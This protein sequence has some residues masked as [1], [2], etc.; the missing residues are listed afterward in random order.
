MT[1]INMIGQP[2]P[3]PVVEAKKAM[4]Q[5][6]S[7]GVIVLVDNPIA[8]QNLEKMAKGTGCGFSWEQKGEGE[9]AVTILAGEPEGSPAV[10]QM[11][12]AGNT[13]GITFFITGDQLGIG[14]EKPGKMLMKGFL[15]TLS[16]ASVTPAALLVVN[17][18]I[19]LTTQGSPVLDELQALSAKG[20]KILTCGQCLTYY[21]LEDTLAVGDVGHMLEMV[22]IMN[23]AL[24]VMTL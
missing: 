14:D 21:G 16:Q 23:A 17:S 13:G 8:V 15:Y 20:T 6:G 22:E 12:P 5:S 11:Q 10:S 9:F 19:K 2:C 3:T 4:S 18:G 7:S 1:T 24:R